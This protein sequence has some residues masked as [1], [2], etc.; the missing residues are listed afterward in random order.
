M[1]DGGRQDTLKQ[2]KIVDS[3]LA[4]LKKVWYDNALRF[5]FLVIAVIN[6]LFVGPVRLKN[7]MEIL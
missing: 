7:L 4:G 5:V 1:K 3:I 6:F 2:E